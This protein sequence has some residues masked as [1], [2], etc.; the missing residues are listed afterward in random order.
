MN[1]PT[2]LSAID[3]LKLLRPRRRI[4][5][6][7]AILLPFLANGD[8]DWAGFSAHVRRTA[9]AGL[10]PAVNMDT[11]FGNLIDDATRRRALDLAVEGD[12]R[13]VYGTS[14]PALVLVATSAPTRQRGRR[15]DLYYTTD[16]SR[17]IAAGPV[18]GYSRHHPR[19]TQSGPTDAVR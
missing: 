12:G 3:P 8:V 7:S 14:G 15:I 6:I 2:N 5:G 11:G 17:P 19:N 13:Q 18:R 16:D 4:E 10:A 9:Q 1:P